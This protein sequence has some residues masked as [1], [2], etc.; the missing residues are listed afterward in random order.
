MLI[1]GATAYIGF[2]LEGVN[3]PIDLTDCIIEFKFRRNEFEPSITRECTVI[4]AGSGQCSVFLTP[5]D[6]SV[7]GTYYYQLKI[8]FADK[9]IMKTELI[10]LF[11]EESLAE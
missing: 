8:I 6:T 11:V 5:E 3:G 9:T 4:D 7:Y 10:S 2:N 1:Q